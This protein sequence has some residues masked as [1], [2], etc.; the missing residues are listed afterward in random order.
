MSA[1]ILN[2][3]TFWLYLT[4]AV[5]MNDCESAESGAKHLMSIRFVIVG[6]CQ[7]V[8]VNTKIS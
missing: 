6:L 1:K 3:W 5:L 4:I 2:I 8:E 7:G